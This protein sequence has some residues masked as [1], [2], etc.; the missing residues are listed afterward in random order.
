MSDLPDGWTIAPLGDLTDSLDSKRVPVS[1][2]E[3]A[4]RIG[5][6]P[7]Y[8]AAGQVGWIDDFLFDEDLILLGED[9]VQFFDPGKRK[10]YAIGGPSWVNNHAHV[11]RPI[12]QLLDHRYLMYYLNAFDYSGHITGTTRLKLT[13]AAMN[14][15]PIRLAPLDE[16]R[17]IATALDDHISRLD[18]GRQTLGIALSRIVRYRDRF[19][20]ASCTGGGFQGS[21]APE[22]LS[23]GV[24][25]GELPSIPATWHWA[26]LGEIADVVGGI[27]KDA[28][29]Q[30]DLGLREV[31]YLRVA[32]VQRGRITTDDVALIRASAAKIDQLRLHMGDVLLNEGG[33][34]DKLARGWIW[35]GQIPD[36]IHQNHVFRARIEKGVLHPKL[37]AWHANSFGK[38]WAEANGKQSVNLASISL[39]KIRLLPVPIPPADEQVPLVNAIE[40]HLEILDRQADACRLALRRA[41]S[42]RRSLLTEAFAGRLVS[43][44]LD[45]EPALT[46]LDRVKVEHSATP[47]PK[48]TRRTAQKTAEA[49]PVQ[50]TLL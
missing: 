30:V 42:L 16:Q 14:R 10:A 22:P 1:A 29:K 37:L 20:A 3:R 23:V 24:Q 38:G 33:D 47:K 25:D 44:A 43:Q 11:L 26:R 31:P 17:R 5:S 50:E 21:S 41:E 7:Y 28:K 48:R 49:S 46:L 9:G 13:K 19:I 36:C 32:N 4:G 2:S 18:S 12:R 34:R 35:E 45:D 27:T 6:V 8:G 40:G 15:I 39:S